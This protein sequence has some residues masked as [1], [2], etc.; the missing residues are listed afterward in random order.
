MIAVRKKRR[1]GFDSDVKHIDKVL[2]TPAMTGTEL[3]EATLDWLRSRDHIPVMQTMEEATKTI[4]FRMVTEQAFAQFLCQILDDWNT[5]ADK[6]EMSVKDFCIIN[7]IKVIFAQAS[8]VIVV[9]AGLENG[10]ASESSIMQ[11]CA[12]K[13]AYVELGSSVERRVAESRKIL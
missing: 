7:Q 3:R 10:P 9:L 13:W 2:H 11:E 1:A 5:W 4:L 6:G 12:E 8:L